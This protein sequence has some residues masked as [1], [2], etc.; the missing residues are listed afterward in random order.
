MHLT[1]A[2][3]QK[4]L[5]Q[6]QQY[7]RTMP[8]LNEIDPYGYTPLIEAAIV[9]DVEI[10]RCLLD[11]GADPNAQDR[12]G[13]TP[14]HWAVENNNLELCKLL[15]DRGAN[16]N[17]YNHMSE[18]VLIKPILREQQALK[19]LLY[20]R[21]ASTQFAYDYIN[22]KLLG[23]RFDLRGEVD[24]TDAEGNFTELS[25][26]GFILEFTLNL[27]RY[28]LQQYQA[29]YYARR[30][31]PHLPH[32]ERIADA[33]EYAA[34]LMH[35]QQYQTDRAPLQQ[36]IFTLLEAPLLLLPVNYRGHA[37]MFIRYGDWW[38]RCDRRKHDQALNGILFYRLKNPAAL[39]KKLLWF[40]LYELKDDQ[41]IDEEL[42]KVLDLE[43]VGRLVIEPQFTGNCTWANVTA[44]IPAALLLL[45]GNVVPNMGILDY[46]QDALM[47][48]R[49]WRQWDQQRAL[50]YCLRNFDAATPTRKA[51][52]AAAL[53]AVLFQR[54]DYRNH[55]QLPMAQKI[56]EVLK[57]PGYEYILQQ[58]ITFYYRQ[59]K[60]PAGT[61]LMKLIEACDTHI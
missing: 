13:G 40:L 46:P 58:Y 29:N 47:W 26:E 42:P 61:N 30:M 41:F 50:Q 37:I 5:L 6:V 1:R 12:I 32:F 18:P 9:N 34:E 39:T 23:H 59:K 11:A 10:A 4:D 60:T 54:F 52:L 38:A 27:V 14:L 22:F 7:A 45:R 20:E 44:A 36:R 15:L 51:S 17:A 55:E 24:I 8:D 3:L 2:I 25:F 35:Y 33:L 31:Q 28:S 56:I 16:P 57:T 43:W 49:D 19:K 48:Y 21:G 53:A